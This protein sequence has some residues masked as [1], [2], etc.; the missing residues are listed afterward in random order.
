MGLSNIKEASLNKILKSQPFNPIP[1]RQQPHSQLIPKLYHH[2]YWNHANRYN[3]LTKY[4]ILNIPENY[5]SSKNKMKTEWF[6]RAGLDPNL[7]KIQT[8][9]NNKI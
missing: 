6:K 8:S 3:I 9:K 7:I 2:L 4:H 5:Q 1:K